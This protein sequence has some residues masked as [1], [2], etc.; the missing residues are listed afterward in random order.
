M[1]PTIPGIFSALIFFEILSTAAWTYIAGIALL[2]IGVLAAKSDVANARGLDKIVALCNLFFALPL[3]V[4]SAQ[5]FSAAA[6]I[7][8]M[9]PKFMPWPLFWTYFVGMGLLSA[10]LSIATK[11]LVRWSGFFF[12]IMMFTFVAMM[13][14]RGTIEKPHDRFA[15]AL[16]LRELSF[17]AGGWVLSTSV[18]DGWPTQWKKTLYTFGRIVLGATAMFY[19]VE[20]FLHPINVPG[21][22]LE[23]VMPGWIPLRPIIGYLTGAILI[24]GGGCILLGKKTRMAATYLGGWISLTVFTVY[25]A[26]L[27]VSFSN[28][29]TDVKVEG[30]NYFTDTLLYAAV[31]LAVAKATPTAN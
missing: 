3:A 5:H 17:G 26:I 15:W 2:L 1:H 11:I 9:V 22:P 4:F 14:I 19:G 27:I 13:D 7:S 6:A 18:V 28:P 12:G 25:L 31:I 10:A 20:H 8:T 23:M 21:V 30:V 24:G 29:S 16:M